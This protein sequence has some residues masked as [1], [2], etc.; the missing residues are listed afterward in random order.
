MPAYVTMFLFSNPGSLY[1]LCGGFRATSLLEIHDPPGMFR[2]PVVLR[3]NFAVFFIWLRTLVLASLPRLGFESGHNCRTLVADFI[4]LLRRP[5]TK[6]HLMPSL[7]PLRG[8]RAHL[9]EVIP[10]RVKRSFPPIGPPGQHP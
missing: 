4:F 1:R 7:F 5:V 2:A 6:L 8:T 9:F 10:F 3:E